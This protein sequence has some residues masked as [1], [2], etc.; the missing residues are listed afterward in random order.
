[1]PAIRLGHPLFFHNIPFEIEERQILREMRI[2]KK[3]SLSELNEPAMERAI[4]QA[5]EEGYRMIEGQGVYRTLAITKVEENRVLTRESETL[6]VGQK[7]VKLLRH[8]DYASLIVATIGPKIETEVDRLS[9]PEPA[10]AYFLERVGAWM[11]DYM[12]IWLDRM[13]EREIV[14]AGYQRTYRFGVGYGDWPLSSQTEVMALT[15]ARKIGIALNEAYIMIPRLSISAVIGW[16]KPG[17]GPQPSP[18]P[19]SD[20]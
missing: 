2:P 9:G 20:S 14:R 16:Q 18:E 17:T 15:E 5:I 3:S 11:A 1:M 8:C 10:H 19:E 13:L 7:M 4:G 12:G 6:F